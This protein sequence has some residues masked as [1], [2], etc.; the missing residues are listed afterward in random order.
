MIQKKELQIKTEEYRN[1]K[2]EKYKIEIEV[3]ILNTTHSVIRTS[4]TGWTSEQST[5]CT[6]GA[7]VGATIIV[8]FIEIWRRELP[9]LEATKICG[10]VPALCT[11]SY[12]FPKNINPA[13]KFAI[14]CFIS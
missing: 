7:L 2:A 9:A 14:A 6:T 12:M 11:L 1:F 3:N 8:H 4:T 10:R 5:Y 13:A